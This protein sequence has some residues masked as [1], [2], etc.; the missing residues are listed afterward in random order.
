M[1][2]DGLTAHLN[3][4][5]STAPMPHGVSSVRLA[6]YE[7]TGTSNQG[8]EALGHYTASVPVMAQCYEALFD[9]KSSQL[10]FFIGPNV[11]IEIS[12]ENI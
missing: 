4:D 5:T 1:E 2:A 8:Y 3:F 12:S 6:T 11:K 7:I 9:A 10:S